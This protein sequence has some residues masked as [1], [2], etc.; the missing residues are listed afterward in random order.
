MAVGKKSARRRSRC[1][2]NATLEAFGDGWSLLIVRDLMFKGRTMFKDF[3]DGEER[4]ATNILAD[5]LKKLEA[6]GI[7]ARERDASDAR[8]VRYRLTEKGLDLAPV[9]V[10]MIVWGARYEDTDAPPRTIRCMTEDRDRFI[11]EIR[12]RWAA[13]ERGAVRSSPKSTS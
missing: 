13:G 4:I 10:E 6:L 1:P 2:L 7:I 9:L 5:R 12:K 11:A 3:L 8:R